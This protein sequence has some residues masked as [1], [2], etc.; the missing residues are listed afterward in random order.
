MQNALG[1]EP[2]P[3]E[4]Y[5]AHQQGAG[6]AANLLR[7]DPNAPLAR[8]QLA[9]TPFGAKTVGQWLNGWQNK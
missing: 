4:L 5:M 3:W 1:R 8:N 2:Q 9:N 6:G 7:G